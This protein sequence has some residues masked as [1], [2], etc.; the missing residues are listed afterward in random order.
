MSEEHYEAFCDAA[1]FDMWCV[2]RIGE[3]TF[4]QG[5]HVINQDSALALKDELEALQARIAQL[6]AELA[7]AREELAS[8]A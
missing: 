2:R 8:R 6:E 7:G 3:R 5:F 1:Y 4:G